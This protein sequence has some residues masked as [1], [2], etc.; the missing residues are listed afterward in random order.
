METVR[1]AVIGGGING[2]GV[3]WEL[4]RKDY[5]VV[6]FDKGEFGAQTSS[7]TTK[8]IHG[9]VRYLEGLHI[10]LVREALLDRGWLLEH[11]PHLVKPMEILLPIYEDSPRGRFTIS[12][13]LTLY[14][15]LAGRKNIARHKKLTVDEL[16]ARAPLVREGL[17]G[18]FSYWDAQV[19]DLQ[20]VRAVVAS[21]VRDGAQAPERTRAE[22][23]RRDGAGW[24]LRAAAGDESHFALAVNAAGPW[25][26]ELL[27]E[28][29]IRAR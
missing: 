12:F 14:D 5:E 23:L 29:D 10:G 28:N 26:N 22:A 21:A 11:L 9:G 18:G 19:D 17:R 7:A 24:S 25:M 16:V 15:L 3:A 4:A 2:A 13:G 8:M 1:I 20:L 6:L 27:S